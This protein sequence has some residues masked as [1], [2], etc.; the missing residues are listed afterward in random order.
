MG[1]Q[2]AFLIQQVPLQFPI[3][4]LSRHIIQHKPDHYCLL[5]TITKD[6]DWESWVLFMLKA[7][8]GTTHWRTRSIEAIRD[9]AKHITA[10]VRNNLLSVN[11][12]NTSTWLLSNLIVESQI[13]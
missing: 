5:L 13:S 10:H 6:H 11:L 9:L 3:V 7:K 4:Y 12:E 8:E 2:N 1:T